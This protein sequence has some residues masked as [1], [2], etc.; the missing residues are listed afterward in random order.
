MSEPSS[1]TCTNEY[2]FFN[3]E[4]SINSGQMF[5]WEKHGI[6]WYGIYGEHVL[7]LNN[8]NSAILSAESKS[9]KEDNSC[10][11]QFSSYPRLHCWERQVFRLNDNLREIFSSF[12]ND[13][14][15]SESVNKYRGLRLMRQEPSQCMISFACASNTNILMI[16]RMLKNL[17]QKFGNRVIVDGNEFFTFPSV[18][19]LNRASQQ[20][21]RQC[22]LGYRTRAVKAVAESIVNGSLDIRSLLRL[23]YEDAKN[24]LMKVY[25]IGNK[26]ADCILLF[27]LEKLDS[28]PIDVWMARV[29]HQNYGWLFNNNQKSLR[30]KDGKVFEKVTA[31][32]YRIL[33][34]NAREYFGRYCGYAQQYLFYNIRQNAGKK[35]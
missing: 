25:G 13:T 11:L 3:P 22:G 14:L 17:C 35:W 6:S 18:D 33:S 32:E 5:L 28:F 12:S 31:L 24:E 29:L 21:L 26:V 8:S 10:E 20:E 27:S 30:I 19:R 7:K 9:D 34:K 23:P 15:V 2:S 4:I 1:Y 16:R